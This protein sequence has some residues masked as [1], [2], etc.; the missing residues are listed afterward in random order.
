MNKSLILTLA[1]AGALIAQPIDPSLLKTLRWRSIGPFRGGRV[2]AVAGV[3]SQPLVYYQGATG[4][5]VWK[6]TDAGITWTPVSDSFFK[7][8]S[9]GA[10]AVAD[11]DPNI[12]YAGMGEA[13]LRANI[14]QGDG[15]YKSTDAGRTW[16]HSGLSDTRSIGKVRIDPR[17]PNL[18]YVAAV[19]HPFGSNSE[20]GV[21]RSRDGGRTWQRVLFVNDRT[22]AVDLALD[23][24]DARVLYASTWQVLRTPS[25][26]ISTG[27]GSGIYKSVDGGDT[28]NQ[29]TKGLPQ[30]DKGKIGIAV[31]PVDSKRVWATVEAEDGG[32]Y[33]SYDAGQTWRRL[34]GDFSVRGRQY[35]Y[36]H[37]FA[38]PQELDTVYTFSSKGFFKST[39]GGVTYTTLRAPHG[40][41]HD[42]WIDPRNHL[43]MI[44]GND[45]GATV[46]FNG[47][48]TWSTLDNQP[49]AQFYE[50]ITDNHFPY[51]IY[52]SQQDNTTVS[53]P[54]RTDSGG[55]AATDWYSVGGGESG[56]L[57][58]DP[59]N[60]E[61]TYGG[62]YWG[63]LTRYDHSTN[64]VRNI[65]IWP[66][67]PG[68]RTAAEMK[69]RFQWT[70][71][72]VIPPLAPDTIYA[73]ANLVFRSTDQ[74]QSWDAI[75]PDLTRN[76]K[77]RE[78][79]GRLEEYY[80]TIFAIAPSPVRKDVIWTGS[81]DGLVHVTVDSG[82]KWINVTPRDLPEW[83]R[84][85][86]IEASPYDAGA[87]YVAANRYQLDDN[88]PYIFKTSDYGKTWKLLTRGIP[89]NVFTRTV[90]A[91][92]GRKGLLYTGTES[93]VYVSFDDGENWQPLQ[94]NLPGVPITDLTIKD[95]DLIAAT[96][97][98]AFWVL[99]DLTLLHQ[100]DTSQTTRL[101]KPR[102]VYR[103]T[104]RF[105]GGA[106]L[107]GMGQNLVSDLAVTYYLPA[108]AN[109]ARL[110]FLD[111]SG[112]IIKSFANVP[113]SAGMNRFEWDLRHPDA[114][115]L[116][117]ETHLSGG[118]LRGPVAIPG[119]Y[120]VKL[121]T[122]DGV[123]E[124]SFA[125]LK[126][127]RLSS[128]SEDYRRQLEFMLGVRDKLSET[129]DAIN[130]IR[131]AL[132][133]MTAAGAEARKQLDEL[134]HE[135][136][137]PGYTG[138]D[139]QMLVFPLK[140]NNRIAALNGYAEGGFAPTSAEYKV[141]NELSAELERLIARLK[142]LL[143]SGAPGAQK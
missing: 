47:G 103:P 57:A 68:G 2:T 72:I 40:D 12:V 34:N 113:A 74:G 100:I 98:R 48:A 53:I 58:P 118:S 78:H 67:Y 120:R 36:G 7:T 8:G 45:G 95:R 96:Q 119:T 70:Y 30:G 109:A 104:R 125:I 82:K 139:D 85:N 77:T 71:P 22:G 1:L 62:S 26:I 42:L 28:W 90:R 117:G 46:T 51:R 32:V 102:D 31:S 110:D 3:A 99:D 106:G 142:H 59:K 24:R 84:I 115:G 33:R 97:G 91:D 116:D 76:D 17:D 79:G 66:D 5:G 126:D 50:V 23:P 89:G 143:E 55:I 19:G 63:T 21:F 75:S 135:L 114:H 108:K 52:G 64:Q 49:T 20:R 138:Y 123:R 27:P 140:L 44:N 38:D 56:Y 137:E 87:A 35:Y 37:I 88:R 43:R 29:L 107:Q 73:G 54:S 128:T 94:L 92:P 69:Y 11:S 10:I 105:R 65:T 83:S 130:R 15:V 93:G 25:G 132:D 4:G 81:D 86:M 61:V 14:S 6:T 112:A 13:C 16:T 134:L 124:Q 101:F 39:D 129:N 121:T 60:P 80:S 41:Y 127:P 122:D 141:F 9:V 18:V 131:R 136:W 133:K 111:Q